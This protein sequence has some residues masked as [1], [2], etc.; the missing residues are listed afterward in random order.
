MLAVSG[1]GMTN[2]ISG[3]AEAQVN[4]RPVLCIAGASESSLESRGA[5]QEFDQLTLAKS[6]TKFAA[7]PS[8]VRH[9]PLLVQKA[10][11]L[12][13]YGTPGP[14]YLDLPADILAA[15][16]PEDSVVYL[17]AIEHVPKMIMPASLLEQTLA[18]LRAAK[19][20][21]VIVGKGVAYGNA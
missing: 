8:N 20:P 21:L 12:T 16:V 18:M 11:K 9:I 4:K 5:F 13:M 3:L 7:R 10:V 14:V 2:C 19:R 6:V 17:P 15:K 1:P